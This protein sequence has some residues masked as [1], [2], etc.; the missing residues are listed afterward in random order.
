MVV[1]SAINTQR[2]IEPIASASLSSLANAY[3]VAES[4]LTNRLVEQGVP[5]VVQLHPWH[6]KAKHVRKV[7]V[8]CR[9]DSHHRL[10]YLRGIGHSVKCERL[11]H[12][13]HGTSHSLGTR[14]LALPGLRS[15]LFVSE[16]CDGTESSAHALLELVCAGGSRQWNAQR[17]HAAMV[18]MEG[19]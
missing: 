7:I 6:L 17:N 18:T 3:T 13:A 1:P 11:Q 9:G 14:R 10:V 16:Y 5:L 2:R 15:R 8:V 12:V 19:D 4:N